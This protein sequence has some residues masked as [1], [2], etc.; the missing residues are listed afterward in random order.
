[1]FE[2]RTVSRFGQDRHLDPAHLAR[3]FPGGRERPGRIAGKDLATGVALELVPATDLEV[4]LDGQEPARDASRVGACLPQVLG[5]RAV[6]ARDRDDLGFVAL[7]GATTDRAATRLVA[8]DHILHEDFLLSSEAGSAGG[9]A[10]RFRR[11][12]LPRAISVSSA[13][14]AAKTGGCRPASQSSS[15]TRTAGSSS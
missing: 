2:A 9:T 3:E 10:S 14:S 13:S 12:R 5:A 7:D 15:S 11:S 6:A 8:R 1:E 4:S